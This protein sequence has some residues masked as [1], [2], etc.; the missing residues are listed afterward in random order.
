MLSEDITLT[1]V[2]STEVEEVNVLRL[3]EA[4]ISKEKSAGKL[5]F[6][7][8]CVK[9]VTREVWFQCTSYAFRV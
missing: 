8:Q 2:R 9:P 6:P 7:H 5:P 1:A 3:E 4:V